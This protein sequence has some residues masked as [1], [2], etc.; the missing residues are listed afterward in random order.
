MGAVIK[1]GG[2]TTRTVHNC[3]RHRYRDVHE[4]L[5][6]SYHTNYHCRLT[7]PAIN[8]SITQQQYKGLRRW[9]GWPPVAGSRHSRDAKGYMRRRVAVRLTAMGL[10]GMVAKCDNLI[11]QIYDTTIDFKH[12]IDLL[13]SNSRNICG[14]APCMCECL[15]EQDESNDCQNIC[16]R[17]THQ[18]DPRTQHILRMV[19][20]LRNDTHA[21]LL[22]Y[23]ATLPTR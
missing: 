21:L 22:L 13:S 20:C 17:K 15:V 3:I 7:T 18:P 12:F 9:P 1:P 5:R 6:R 19:S 23:V 4:D 11:S 14:G 8:T 16:Q 10:I 2:G